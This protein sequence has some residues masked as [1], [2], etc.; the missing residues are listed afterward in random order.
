MGIS[1]GAAV[2]AV[3]AVPPANRPDRIAVPRD[4]RAEERT[5]LVQG[6]EEPEIRAGFG[7][8]TLSPSAA[9]L[10]TIDA[11]LE[12][13][14]RIVPT[15]Q[16]LRDR[17]RVTQSTRPDTIETRATAVAPDVRRL[18]TVRPEPNAA[19]RNFVTDPALIQGQPAAD[20]STPT[21]GIGASEPVSNRETA[22]N[23]PR[24]SSSS[25]FDIRV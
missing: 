19:A 6:P 2:R 14:R 16:E 22:P 5:D 23:T 11:N 25:R 18:E 17:A 3:S 24:E 15:V 9:A 7:E 1:I 20:T 4:S 8:N 21:P 13:A 12:G 10:E